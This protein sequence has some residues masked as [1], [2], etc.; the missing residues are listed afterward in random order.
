MTPVFLESP[1]AG[2]VEWSTAYARDCMLHSIMLGE[3]PFASHILYAQM[4]DD[5]N[6]LDRA[7]GLTCARAWREKAERV[8]VYTDYGIS[9][10]MQAGIDHASSLGKPIEFREVYSDLR[11][12]LERWIDETTADE[13]RAKPLA[14]RLDRGV[15]LR[16]YVSP[17]AL[18]RYTTKA[19][20]VLRYGEKGRLGV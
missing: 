12:E 6:P 18:V 20:R 2:D 13:L 9:S 10:G 3:A 16:R 19:L 5:T 15:Y 14:E 7:A 11:D 8:A 17:E 4:L 1:Y